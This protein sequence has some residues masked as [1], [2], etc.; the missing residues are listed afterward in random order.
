M[1]REQ[2]NV[3]HG[4][5]LLGAML[6]CSDG[7]MTINM[8]AFGIRSVIVPSG[9]QGMKRR[10]KERKRNVVRDLRLLISRQVRTS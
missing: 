9:D 4:L 3:G 6:T 7:S 5:G 2:R 1:L 10:K 8:E